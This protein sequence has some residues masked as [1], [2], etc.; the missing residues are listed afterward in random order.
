MILT[1]IITW[2]CSLLYEQ[3]LFPNSLDVEGFIVFDNKIIT[4]H[5][6]SFQVEVYINS[7]NPSLDLSSGEISRKLKKICGQKL[8]DEAQKYINT[9][10][11]LQPGQVAVTSADNTKAKAIYHV[12][13]PKYIE[14]ASMRVSVLHVWLD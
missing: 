1:N 5:F 6:Y 10:G 4:A 7:T 11:P 13:L 3:G 9:S 8:V 12:A 14:T 2:C